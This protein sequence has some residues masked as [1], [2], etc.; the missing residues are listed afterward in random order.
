MRRRRTQPPDS[1]DLL[2]DTITNA[3]GGILFLAILVV[4]LMQ[5]NRHRFDSSV[6]EDPGAPERLAQL[7]TEIAI[8][9][10]TLESQSQLMS[11]L[12]LTTAR[13]LLDELKVA[14]NRRDGLR[15]Q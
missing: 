14:T 2:L 5:K 8:R 15:A 7:R 6:N 3:F 1:L 12:S 9:R 4:L 11:Q 13:E 10:R